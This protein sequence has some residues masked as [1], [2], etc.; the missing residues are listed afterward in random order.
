MPHKNYKWNISLEEGEK[1]I[2]KTIQEI[3]HSQ[4][5]ERMNLTELILLIQNRTKG[6]DIQNNR[7]KK[8]ILNFANSKLG[9]IQGIIDKH[10]SLLYFDSKE[11]DYIQLHTPS[12]VNEWIFVE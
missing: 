3:L 2:L 10:E 1:I 8:S 7:K 11:G 4:K 5:N 9:G 12:F 6:M